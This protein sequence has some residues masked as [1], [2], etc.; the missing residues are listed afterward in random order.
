VV[1]ESDA[2][3]AFRDYSGKFGSAASA[4]RRLA[5]RLH[6]AADPGP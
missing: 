1:R 2:A 3:F 6:L 4:G 5:L